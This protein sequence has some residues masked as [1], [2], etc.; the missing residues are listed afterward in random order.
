[1]KLAVKLMIEFAP[2]AIFFV[3]STH[4]DPLTGTAVLMAATVV[5]VAVMRYF[6]SQVALMALITAGT[7]LLFGA[8]TIIFANQT[9]I[10]MKP[11][12]VCLIFAAILVAGLAMDRPL[13]QKLLGQ[14]LHISEKGWRVL[15]WLWVVY[16]VFVA[17]LNEYMRREYSFNTWAFFKA[18]GVMPL[19]IIYALPQMLLLRRYRLEGSDPQHIA[20]PADGM[21][22]AEAVEMLADADTPHHK[23]AAA[24]DSHGMGSLRTKLDS[25]LALEGGVVCVQSSTN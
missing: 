10:Q 20:E 22:I 12:I 7:G 15:T 6:F 14:E 8:I 9:Y 24:H 5:S 4:Y 19:T 13:F 21:A 23:A 2:L 18:F 17:V 16:F 3:V 25:D 1:M 11:T